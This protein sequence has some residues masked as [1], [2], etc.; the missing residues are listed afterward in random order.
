MI[1]H[2]KNAIIKYTTSVY[3]PSEDS[4][5][6]AEA[7]LSE[8]KDRERILEVGCG[9][10]I[11]STV[12]KANTKAKITGIDI[13]PYAAACT[14][15]NGVDVIIGDLLS[16]IKGKFDII[17]FNPPYLPDIEEKIAGDKIAKNWINV[18]LDGGDDGRRII[19][20][21]L[22]EAGSRLAEKGRIII[23]VSSLTGI[24]EVKSMMRSLNYAVKEIAHERFMFEQLTV[25][26]GTKRQGF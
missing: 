2:Y 22:E 8:V 19:F 1:I 21:F 20:R 18:A 9:S 15:E 16:C 17:I 14:K 12:I 23:L 5:L 25:L 24:E 26:S 3:A 13:N 11:I 4:F 7:A 6:L 10:G